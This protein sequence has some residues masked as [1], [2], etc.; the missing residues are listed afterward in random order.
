MSEGGSNNTAVKII[1]II[2]GVVIVVVVSCG[3]LGYFFIKAMKET[4]GQAMEGMQEWAQD[5]EQSQAAA[6][7]FLK[8]IQAND[9]EAAYQSTTEQFKK[10]M[11]RKDF[12]ELVKKLPAFKEPHTGLGPDP[13][14]PMVPPTSRQALPSNYRYQCQVRSKDGKDS[15]DLTI[16]VSKEGGQMKVDQLTVKKSITGS[17]EKEEKD[18]P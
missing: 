2:G 13:T 7:Q 9:L 8:E 11:N 1:A 4:V 3:V 5:M 16:A 6:D 12:D 14:A 18:E 17:E 15:L 10:R